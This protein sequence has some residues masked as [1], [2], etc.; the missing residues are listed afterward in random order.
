MATL[1]HPVCGHELKAL[2]ASIADQQDR[3]QPDPMQ[4]HSSQQS[5]G[6]SED[7]CRC[8]LT[9]PML[10]FSESFDQYATCSLR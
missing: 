2:P 6:V 1:D 3:V 9:L 10:A 8:W 4:D 5:S 7:S